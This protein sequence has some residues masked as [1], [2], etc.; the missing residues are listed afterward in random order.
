MKNKI[1]LQSI[2]QSTRQKA[3]RVYEAIDCSNGVFANSASKNSRSINHIVFRM[4]DQNLCKKVVQD[5]K[6]AGFES[7]ETPCGALSCIIN[8][9]TSEASVNKFVEVLR[10]FIQKPKL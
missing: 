1:D 9:Q 6:A 7:S 5:L 8:F 4:K 2:E 3:S 10:K